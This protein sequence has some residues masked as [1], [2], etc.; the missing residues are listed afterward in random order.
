MTLRPLTKTSFVVSKLKRRLHRL[1][2][3]GNISECLLISS[4]PGTEHNITDY[5]F[6]VNYTVSSQSNKII[7]YISRSQILSEYLNQVVVLI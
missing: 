2:G 5:L 3:L 6:D 4:L 1:I 7:I